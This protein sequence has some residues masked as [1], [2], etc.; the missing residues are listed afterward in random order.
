MTESDVDIVKRKVT[1]RQKMA[2][3]AAIA[4]EVKV[5]EDICTVD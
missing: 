5:P 4:L 2:R 3:K 1:S